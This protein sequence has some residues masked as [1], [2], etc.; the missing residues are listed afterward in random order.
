VSRKDLHERLKELVLATGVT[1]AVARPNPES[2]RILSST[3]RPARIL[4]GGPLLCD[5]VHLSRHA[6][7]AAHVLMLDLSSSGQKGEK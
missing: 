3:A 5:S 7:P 6:P 1:A 4:A 2:R